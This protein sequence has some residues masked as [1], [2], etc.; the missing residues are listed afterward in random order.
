MCKRAE[1]VRAALTH[2]AIAWPAITIALTEHREAAA[3]K[4]DGDSGGA[5]WSHKYADHTCVRLL[6]GQIVVFG[7]LTLSHSAPSHTRT[8]TSVFGS[9]LLALRETNAVRQ[10]V[11]ALYPRQ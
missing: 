4:R 2:K 10:R 8:H 6:L 7:Y 1:A 5:V 11:K 9:S 3:Q